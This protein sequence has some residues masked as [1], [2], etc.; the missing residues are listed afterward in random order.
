MLWRRY[1]SPSVMISPV[2]SIISSSFVMSS[3]ANR[4]NPASG[5]FERRMPVRLRFLGSICRLS[6]SY[7]QRSGSHSRPAMSHSQRSL[8][9]QAPSLQEHPRNRYGHVGGQP[10]RFSQL[11]R[12]AS[13][14]NAKKQS[15]IS[16]RHTS[17]QSQVTLTV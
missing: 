15:Q 6:Q 2:Y 14:F 17:A 16:G 12:G 11:L 8:F 5:M 1:V 13:S 7:Q 4:P 10:H 3:N 9:V